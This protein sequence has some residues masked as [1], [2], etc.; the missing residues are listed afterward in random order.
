MPTAEVPILV[1]AETLA[2]AV[3]VSLPKDIVATAAVVTDVDTS[4]K[5]HAVLPKPLAPHAMS[6]RPCQLSDPND[7]VACV[8]GW[9]DDCEI[10]CRRCLI[11]A[12][13]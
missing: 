12:K 11:C 2:A 6:V 10:S 5:P 3:T 7:R 13:V 9:K 4:P 1:A 8:S